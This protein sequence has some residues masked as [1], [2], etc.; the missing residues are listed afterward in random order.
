MQQQCEF[1]SVKRRGLVYSPIFFFLENQNSNC[2]T[3]C[4][5]IFLRLS[6][7]LFTVEM[8]NERSSINLISYIAIS[9]H[10]IP[11]SVLLAKPLGNLPVH[12]YTSAWKTKTAGTMAKWLVRWT[13]DRVARVRTLV[14]T[15]R[16]VLGQETLLS[17][18]LS[19]LSLP[20][21]IAMD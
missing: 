10:S 19:V 6:G 20:R 21:C 14:G 5:G 13:P 8:D 1:K 12:I 16:C 17:L 18:C 11:S 9:D 15:V 7:L 2:I 4:A 3:T